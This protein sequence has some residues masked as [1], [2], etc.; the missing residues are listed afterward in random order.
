[1]AR[2]VRGRRAI[3]SSSSDRPP[4]YTLKR[5][6]RFD[7][8]LAESCS[9]GQPF[10]FHPD[11]R[12]IG[13]GQIVDAEAG[14]VVVA[15]VELCRV[16]MQMRFGD[17][18]IAT[19]QAAFEDREEVFD[20]VGVPEHRAH[21]FLGAVIN[22][23]VAGESRT[24]AGIDWA[25]VSHQIGGLIDVRGDD[26]AEGFGGDIWNVEAAHRTVA[27]DQRQHDC[28]RR[29]FAFPVRRLAAGPPGEVMMV[30]TPDIRGTAAKYGG[31]RHAR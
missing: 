28:L 2:Q 11:E 27:L 3:G 21:V 16:A 4:F 12:A 20:R 5:G 25:T 18:E 24:N 9:I 22:P 13:A 7:F 8:P 19:E 17:M 10:A 6:L 26:R 15:K 29:D 30:Y 14:A 23:A 1:M 31:G